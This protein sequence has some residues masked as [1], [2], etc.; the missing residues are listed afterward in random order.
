MHGGGHQGEPLEINLLK[1]NSIPGLFSRKFVT[2]VIRGFIHVC[3][4]S[5]IQRLSIGKHLFYETFC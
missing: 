4:M 1:Y 3:Y 2:V 5:V